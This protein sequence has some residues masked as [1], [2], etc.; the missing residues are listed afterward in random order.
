MR[1]LGMRVL[2]VHASTIIK[3]VSPMIKHDRSICDLADLLHPHPAITEGVQE[4]AHM[5]LGTSFINLKYFNLICDYRELHI[6]ISL[7][8]I[9]ESQKTIHI[10][11]K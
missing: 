8:E 5:L 11:R 4:C 1:I 3:A 6:P 10:L 2:D 7:S 9:Q